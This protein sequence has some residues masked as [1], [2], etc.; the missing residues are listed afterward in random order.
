MWYIT[1]DLDQKEHQRKKVWNIYGYYVAIPP[2]LCMSLVRTGNALCSQEVIGWYWQYNILS[3]LWHNKLRVT[4]LLSTCYATVLPVFF[5]P[6]PIACLANCTNITLPTIES[7]NCK[8]FQN[9]FC[10]NYT[11]TPVAL[12]FA[13]LCLKQDHIRAICFFVIP[14]A[15]KCKPCSI[16]PCVCQ[17]LEC[18]SS[19][20]VINACNVY[21]RI[22]VDLCE[23]LH[24]PN[25]SCTKCHHSL[26]FLPLPPWHYRTLTALPMTWAASNCNALGGNL[27]EQSALAW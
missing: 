7:C 23:W 5:L 6:S 19:F 25:A 13:S 24:D 20:L 4:K 2:V 3:A 26:P 9:W 14:F 1:L 17:Q 8:G 15:L 27:L 11:S 21:L 16:Y 18:L 22:G 10:H 12:R